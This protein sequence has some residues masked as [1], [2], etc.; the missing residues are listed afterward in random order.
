MRP[1]DTLARY[2]GEE[3][4]ILLPDTVLENGIQAMTRLQ[5]ALTR[6]FFLAGGEKILVTFSAGV[7]QLAQGE[8]PEDAIKRA[9]AAMYLAKRAGKNRVLGA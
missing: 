5:R 2:G 6:R 4:V 8:S 1:Q 9:D 3:F 7:A